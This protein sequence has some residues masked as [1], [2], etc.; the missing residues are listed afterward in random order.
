MDPEIKNT[1]SVYKALSDETRLSIV[2][3]VA[4]QGQCHTG[5]CSKAISLSQPTLSHHIKVLIKANILIVKKIGTSKTYTLNVEYLD[6]LGI[7]IKLP[8]CVTSNSDK[9]ELTN[10]QSLSS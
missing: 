9:M 5:D 6:K 7:K 3:T 4:F 1:L 8:N 2:R 10:P